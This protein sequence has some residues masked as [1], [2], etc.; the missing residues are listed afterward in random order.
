M[1]DR[2]SLCDQQALRAIRRLAAQ[3]GWIVATAAVTRGG[4]DAAA[5]GGNSLPAEEARRLLDAG[6][7]LLLAPA[8]AIDPQIV[9]RWRKAEQA[10][11]LKVIE[12]VVVGARALAS[13]VVRPLRRFLGRARR[14]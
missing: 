6:D 4:G 1:A 12:D 14:P 7:A 5:A 9:W 13:R 3:R 11:E 10:A 8:S 2:G